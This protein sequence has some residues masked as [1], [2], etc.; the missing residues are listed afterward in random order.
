MSI[1]ERC[2]LD[3]SNGVKPRTGL[4]VDG[5]C[6]F[7]LCIRYDAHVCDKCFYQGLA[8]VSFNRPQQVEG[9]DTAQNEA[10]T[11]ERV[12]CAIRT[13]TQHSLRTHS[14]QD[15]GTSPVTA[16][17]ACC[18]A[19]PY[20]PLRCILLDAPGDSHCFQSSLRHIRRCPSATVL[21]MYCTRAASIMACRHI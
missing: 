13:C 21:C 9:F 20:E 1:V 10:D 5:I 15:T 8:A 19:C 18:Q 12:D 14:V 16:L 17:R 4:Y 2:S 7:T 3:L 6:P 11:A